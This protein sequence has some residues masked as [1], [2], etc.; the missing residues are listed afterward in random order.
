MPLRAACRAR[1]VV[2]RRRFGVRRGGGG[3]RAARLG[4]VAW[5][6]REAICATR[7][8]RRRVALGFVAALRRARAGAADV[9]IAGASGCVV[10]SPA[11]RFA[12]GRPGTSRRAARSRRSGPYRWTRH[13]LYVGSSVMAVGRR[14]SR[15]A[16]RSW[17]CWRRSTWSSTITAAMRTEEAHLRADVRRRLRPLPRARSARRW[18]DGSAS[19][20]RCATANTGRSPACVAGLRFLRSKVLLST[21]ID[22]LRGRAGSVAT[23]ERGRLAQW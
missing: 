17:R 9:A 14:R 20:A 11:K 3:R 16:A 15:R 8:A 10:A 23:G 4:R 19:S 13:P 18:R 12:S 1:R 7:L 22:A 2:H 5:T 6:T 21:I